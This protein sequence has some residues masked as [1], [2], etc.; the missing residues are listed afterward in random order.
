MV[1]KILDG[2]AVLSFLLTVGILGVSFY[3]Y[4][5]V[6]SP[7]FETTIKNKLLGEINKKLPS[8]I[9]Q[10]LPKTTGVSIPY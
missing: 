1:R 6:T 8:S 10:Q 3:V 4:K 9:N 5:Y 7:Q 2:L